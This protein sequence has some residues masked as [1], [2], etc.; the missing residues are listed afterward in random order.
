M[1]NFEICYACKYSLLFHPNYI[2]LFIDKHLYRK[3]NKKIL[4]M[5][6]R[7]ITNISQYILPEYWSIFFNIIKDVKQSLKEIPEYQFIFQSHFHQEDLD[8]NSFRVCDSCRCAFC[9]MHQKIAP[10]MLFE[11]KPKSLCY[12]CNWCIYTL[13]TETIKELVI[14]NIKKISNS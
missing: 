8:Y 1:D 11:Y 2:D 10:L 3:P 12:V 5:A 6:Y 14:E 4:L 7:L 13:P 9:P